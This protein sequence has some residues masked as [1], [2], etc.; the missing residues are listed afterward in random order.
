MNQILIDRR[1]RQRRKQKQRPVGL[2][3]AMLTACVVTLIG[4][5]SDVEPLA[6]LLRAGLSA[7]L[8]GVLVSLGLGVIRT[9]N[10]K[11]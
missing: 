2:L 7:V 3:T 1:N 8:M 11:P 6:V 9:A 5:F 10:S 4:V